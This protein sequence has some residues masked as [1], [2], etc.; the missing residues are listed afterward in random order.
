MIFL[1]FSL[2]NNCVPSKFDWILLLVHIET[3]SR[4]K[5]VSIG[6]RTFRVNDRSHQYKQLVWKL[7]TCCLFHVDIDSVGG[8]LRGREQLVKTVSWIMSRYKCN[9]IMWI[10][11]KPNLYIGQNMCASSD[12]AWINMYINHQKI[13]NFTAIELCSNCRNV[14]YFV[15]NNDI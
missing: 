8:E 6:S 3:C 9:K 10:Y 13:V 2:Q 11:C 15:M 12:I 1:R 14:I 5:L 7:R 4:H